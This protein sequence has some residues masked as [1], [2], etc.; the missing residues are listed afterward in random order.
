MINKVFHGIYKT[1]LKY[2]VELANQTPKGKPRQ[3]SSTVRLGQ[4]KQ[5]Y[6]HYELKVNKQTLPAQERQR[7]V[8]T[9]H[10]KINPLARSW[11]RSACLCPEGDW[12]KAASWLWVLENSILSSGQ[13]GVNKFKSRI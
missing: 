4:S 8:E 5:R 6:S 3:P 7:N 12:T 10:L 2:T 9:I 13:F 1:G 11:I